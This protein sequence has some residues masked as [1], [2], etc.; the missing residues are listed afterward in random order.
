M[1]WGAA[2]GPGAAAPV[3]PLSP[4]R[5][6]RLWSRHYG[7]GPKRLAFMILL[8]VTDRKAAR[9]YASRF[10]AACLS[11]IATASEPWALTIDEVRNWLGGSPAR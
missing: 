11:R 8:T 2:R 5:G 4:G 1:Q 6:S 3:G 7:A 10:A 9:E